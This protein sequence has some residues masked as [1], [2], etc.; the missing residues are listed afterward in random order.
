DVA[1]L[2]P[3]AALT[4][5]AARGD[6]ATLERHRGALDGTEVLAYD[7]GVTLARRLVADG[8]SSRPS[9]G[10][11]ARPL[12]GDPAARTGR[13][14]PRKGAAG[15][16]TVL[17]RA[18]PHGRRSR[19]AGPMRVVTSAREFSDV[20][21]TERALGRSVGLVPTM[22]ALHAGHRSLIERAASDCDVVAVTVF[23]NPLQFNDAD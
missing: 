19:R 8:A 14:K 5:P 12:S 2:G 11:G 18:H 21:E 4:G 13:P 22:G 9:P 20:L 6:D 15:A 3:A 23:V 7:A 16:R 10:L 1:E 17:P